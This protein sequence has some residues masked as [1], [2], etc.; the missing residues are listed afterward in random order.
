MTTAE[1]RANAE[2][3]RRYYETHEERKTKINICTRRANWNACHYI[4]FNMQDYDEQ[5]GCKCWKQGGGYY[6][7][8]K[9]KRFFKDRRKIC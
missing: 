6:E 7:K 9:S 5:H 1:K 8:Q 4:D 2:R 3:L